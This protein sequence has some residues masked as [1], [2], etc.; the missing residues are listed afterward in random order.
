MD[1]QEIENLVE[2]YEEV[3]FNEM[4]FIYDKFPNFDDDFFELRENY[5]ALSYNFEN[6]EQ[7]DTPFSDEFNAYI[8]IAKRIIDITNEI[9]FYDP[10]GYLNEILRISKIEYFNIDDFDPE[11]YVEEE[12]FDDEILDN[13]F[14]NRS[15]RSDEDSFDD[16]FDVEKHFGLD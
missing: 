4:G 9:E 16:G 11:S 2:K 5:L 1:I 8:N 14:P 6:E 3:I 15:D 7:E 10:N 12:D 13:M